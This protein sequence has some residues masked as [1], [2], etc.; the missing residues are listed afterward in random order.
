MCVKPRPHVAPPRPYVLYRVWVSRVGECVLCVVCQVGQVCFGRRTLF[1]CTL[2][3]YRFPVHVLLM[4][5]T[6]S[7]SIC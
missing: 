4:F 7:S 6:D 5:S 1:I 3:T 2:R